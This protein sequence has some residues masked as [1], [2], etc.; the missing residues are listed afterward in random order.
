MKK[1]KRKA[2]TAEKARFVRAEGHKDALKFA[3]AIGLE[4]DYQNDVKAKKDVI[5]PSG[6][7]HS[8][9]SGKKRW[10]IF[11]YGKNRFATDDA[12]QS[13]NGIGQLLIACIDSF[14]R[15]F[16][17]Y[18][19][20]KKAYKARLREIMKQLFEKFQETCLIFLA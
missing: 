9:K 2:M 7:A 8:V 1:R 20:N 16:K 13:M 4:R 14:P 5:D 11:L 15:T 17:E 19:A 10:Q 3:L 18:Q 12:F 6:D